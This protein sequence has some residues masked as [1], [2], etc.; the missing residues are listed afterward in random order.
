MGTG[1]LVGLGLVVLSL[2]VLLTVQLAEPEPEFVTRILA[3]KTLVV[4]SAELALVIHAREQGMRALFPAVVAGLLLAAGDITTS[5]AASD[6]TLVAVLPSVLA[7]DVVLG[8]MLALP[9]LVVL[10]AMAQCENR[11]PRA[12]VDPRPTKLVEDYK[13]VLAQSA[14]S[15]NL[16]APLTQQLLR[17]HIRRTLEAVQRGYATLAIEHGLDEVQARDRRVVDDYVLAVPPVS[18]AVPGP[19]IASI[20][21][22]SKFVPT[23]VA[24]AATAAAWFGGSR[25]NLD[26]VSEPLG[27]AVPDQVASYAVDAL[28]LGMAFSLLMLLLTPAIRRRDVL[29]ADRRICEREAVL[30]D[31]VLHVRRSSR[32][33]EYLLAGLPALPLA[34]FGGAMLAYAV[35]GLFVQASPQG[36]LAGLVRRADVMNLGPVS[37]AI[38]AQVLVVAAAAWIA[39]IVRTRRATRVVFI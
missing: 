38:L 23:I 4:A 24:G 11:A 33:L 19:T 5:S 32:R 22:L 8:S 34:L 1:I 28:A 37:G 9:V 30:M 2:L 6:V 13:Q 7:Y 29:L 26:S 14:R 36:P 12:N 17:R 10:I 16:F 25:W 35:A 15:W 20:F 3:V 39:S 18:R 31:D 27:R 21:V